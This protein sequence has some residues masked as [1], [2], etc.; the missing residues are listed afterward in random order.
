[1]SRTAARVIAIV[2]GISLVITYF[3]HR[4]PQWLDS[5]EVSILSERT[6][7]L[8]GH[9]VR[10]AIDVRRDQREPPKS[11]QAWQDRVTN[12]FLVVPLGDTEATYMHTRPTVGPVAHM[13]D[14]EDT[15]AGRSER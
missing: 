12:R 6:A 8:F 13:A 15:T 7:R 2:Y 10:L 4:P 1:M 3:A 5:V 11:S 9:Q 14:S